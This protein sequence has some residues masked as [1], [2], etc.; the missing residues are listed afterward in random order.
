MSAL[1]ERAKC[2]LCD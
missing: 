2:Q 1:L